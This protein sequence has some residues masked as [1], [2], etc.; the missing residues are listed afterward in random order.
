MSASF[1]CM[2]TDMYKKLDCSHFTFLGRSYLDGGL[3][4]NQPI[5]DEKTI[6]ISPFCGASH[7]CPRDDENASDDASK[8]EPSKTSSGVNAP[9][10]SPT[11]EGGNG[12]AIA[13]SKT[14][15]PLSKGTEYFFSA[16]INGLK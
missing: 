1:F 9:T 6:K 16:S 10:S 12:A 11:T 13:S 4:N 14:N 3:S 8:N 5:L 2:D 7:I 15:K